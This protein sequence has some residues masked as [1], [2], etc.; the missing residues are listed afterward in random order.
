MIQMPSYVSAWQ[1]YPR[2]AAARVNIPM[3]T[4]KRGRDGLTKEE[5]ATD[6]LVVP[7]GGLH[8]SSGATA[9]HNRG[10]GC[11]ERRCRRPSR[12]S[13]GRPG[14]G[15]APHPG[16]QTYRGRERWEA[17]LRRAGTQLQPNRSAGGGRGA[18]ASVGARD[19]ENLPD[20]RSVSIV[21]SS[22]RAAALMRASSMA[23]VTGWSQ[24]GGMWRKRASRA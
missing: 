3:L 12:W 24:P 22:R 9:V 23:V 15:R 20:E 1:P 2:N 19:G 6:A 14:F 16:G 17:P 11:P 4:F 10:P 13:E 18:S 7:D 5:R 21:A 8:P